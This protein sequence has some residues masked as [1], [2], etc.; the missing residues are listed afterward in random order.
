MLKI[1]NEGTKVKNALGIRRLNTVGKESVNLRISR[2]KLSRMKNREQK[3]LS[4]AYRASRTCRKN[5][6]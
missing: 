4:R 5:A 6:R 3:R 1:K 2:W